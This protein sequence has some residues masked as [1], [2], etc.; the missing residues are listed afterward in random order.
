MRSSQNF[1]SFGQTSARLATFLWLIA[2]VGFT[3]E[4]V[5]EAWNRTIRQAAFA[6]EGL[7]RFRNP[8]YQYECLGLGGTVLR[9]GPDGFTSAAGAGISSKGVIKHL[10]YLCYQYWW[11]EEAHRHLPFSLA[12]DYGKS[13]DPAQVVSFRHHL[14]IA[15]GFLTID[16]G[17]RADSV[18]TDNGQPGEFQSHREMFI[19][20]EG[21]LVMRV[22]DAPDAPLPFQARVDITK[23][24]RIYLNQGY[25]AKEHAPWTGT[26][27]PKPGGLV[28]EAN[29]PK[30][31]TATLAIACEGPELSVDMQRFALGSKKPGKTITFY[32]APSS[33][34][35]SGDPVSAAWD[36]AISARARGYEA[37]RRETAQWWKAFYARSAVN[38]PDRELA[39]WYA[40]STYY[41]GAFFGRTDIPPGCNGSSIELFG[42][43]ICPEYDLVLNQLALLYANHF[44]E[45]RR[46]VGWLERAL[47]RTERYA[48]EGLTLHKVSVKYQGGAKF[49]PLMGYDGAILTPPTEGEGVWAYEDFAGNN[50]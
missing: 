22:S 29:R 23:M 17:L 3:A 31:C 27:V 35:E 36:K 30:T 20:P 50:A 41:L 28:V 7:E 21:V 4:T 49:G 44:D 48:T 16:L 38:L 5:P 39:T 32:L 6:K 40:R 42:G 13:F 2:G 47:L 1:C 43:A 37:M 19:T 11:D 34:Y 26:G 8:Q 12:G 14:D 33:S 9:V 18:G 24:V 25:Y 15:S 45:A 10:P 46:V